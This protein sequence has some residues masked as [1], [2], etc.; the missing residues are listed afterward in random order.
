[1]ALEAICFE[2]LALAFKLGILQGTVK[3]DRLEMDQRLLKP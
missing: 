2:G 3:R 1:M